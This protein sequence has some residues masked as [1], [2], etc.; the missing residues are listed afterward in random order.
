MKGNEDQDIK[1]TTSVVDCK[2]LVYFIM[3]QNRLNWPLS[4]KIIVTI[5]VIQYVN[6]LS[7]I[8][9]FQHML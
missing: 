7:H 4:I 1:K 2:S 8:L 3:A 6:D 5:C 9:L